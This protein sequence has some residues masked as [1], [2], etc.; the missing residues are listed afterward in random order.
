MLYSPTGPRLRSPCSIVRS[1]GQIFTSIAHHLH[2]WTFHGFVIILWYKL[3]G[4]DLSSSSWFSVSL[5]L[6]PFPLSMFFCTASASLVWTNSFFKLKCFQHDQIH[7]SN[8]FWLFTEFSD[9]NCRFMIAAFWWNPS[10]I[11]IY[12]FIEIFVDANIDRQKVFLDMLRA[13]S[14]CEIHFLLSISN[15]SF[16]N[17]LFASMRFSIC[18][19]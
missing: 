8:A 7:W 5:C 17:S 10:R 19:K 1:T 18:S 3:F 2:S 4:H 14:V 6:S 13:E 11:D 15:K 12:Y 16:S 9:T